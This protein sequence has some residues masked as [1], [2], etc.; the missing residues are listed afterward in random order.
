MSKNSSKNVPNCKRKLDLSKEDAAIP[1]KGGRIKLN[2]AIQISSQV[3]PSQPSKK[4]NNG[5]K[6]IN[7][8]NPRPNKGAID[9]NKS[10]IVARRTT[11]NQKMLNIVE[12]ISDRDAI[13]AGSSAMVESITSSGGNN[14]AIPEKKREKY[15]KKINKVVPPQQAN[16]HGLGATDDAYDGV[17]VN[18]DPRDDHFSTTDDEVDNDDNNSVTSEV[19][20]L[21]T[22]PP[23]QDEIEEEVQQW[24]KNPAVKQFFWEM[25]ADE[26]KERE[27][28]MI[29]TVTDKVSKE[30]RSINE[31]QQ[32]PGNDTTQK[33]NANE[34][35]NSRAVI[36]RT[37]VIKSPSD[38]TIYQPAFKVN[39]QSDKLINKI[40][41]FVEGI[42]IESAGKSVD[43]RRD[44]GQD[45]HKVLHTPPN[46][47]TPKFPDRSQVIDNNEPNG[48]TDD[49]ERPDGKVIGEEL[50]KGADESK[51]A[52]PPP[53][54]EFNDY[55][56]LN[57]IARLLNED[58]DFFHITC[59][60]DSALKQKIERGE[61][62][63]LERLL[64]K[65]KGGSG[66][67]METEGDSRVE[68]VSQGG[69]T[70]FKPVKDN[71]IHGL[72]KWE[73]A[74]RV[75]A[76][77]YTEANPERSGE[78]WQYIHSINVAASSFQWHNVAYY[79]S[80]F[81]QLMA[82]KPNRSWAKLY[83]QG[84]NLA[85]RDPIGNRQSS[86]GSNES[87]TRGS[88]QRNGK[89]SKRSWRD[90][91]CWNYNKNRC[92]KTNC[93]FDHRCT[94]C[95]RWNHGN[96][97]CRKRLGKEK[98]SRESSSSTGRHGKGSPAGGRQA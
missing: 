30:N 97:N 44:K 82:Y 83:N 90:D 92:H 49:D 84:W 38:T 12:N 21:P 28:E 45:P 31:R 7:S 71:Q 94:Y 63:D 34:S 62:I 60:I 32:K 52:L 53:R 29:K 87:D 42:R 65:D 68:L 37:E 13:E 70:Y 26:F 56:Q 33:D 27:T 41:N 77:I 55:N 98:G 81:R 47:P 89:N 6:N 1:N 36:K 76:A 66:G 85:M 39:D 58:D 2:T 24:K 25:F 93:E 74:F 79:N 11:R 72:R 35:R 17:E 73:Q 75:Y 46:R 10:P 22:K 14:N 4:K 18:V 3:G 67:Y 16:I 78:V 54:G 5:T 23:T 96:Y 69:H 20:V 43:S 91:C 19:V 48:D 8:I 88:N 51:A 57:R 15:G 61:Y 86:S 95:G 40:S 80:T 50:I 9:K 59:H 64:P